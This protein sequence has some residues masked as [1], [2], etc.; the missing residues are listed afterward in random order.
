MQKLDILFSFKEIQFQKWNK[1]PLTSVWLPILLPPRFW[2]GVD[3]RQISL[4]SK[5]RILYIYIFIHWSLLYFPE[6]LLKF[7]K[8]KIFLQNIYDFLNL[9]NK[10]ISC[11]NNLVWL[12]I[13]KLLL[14]LITAKLIQKGPKP[15]KKPRPMSM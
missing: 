4:S 11:I 13:S 9:R 5:P 6:F 10:F 12:L 1:N 14:L 15:H 8:F 2:N 7:V 3:W